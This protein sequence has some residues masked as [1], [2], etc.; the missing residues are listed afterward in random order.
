MPGSPLRSWPQDMV[1]LGCVPPSAEPRATDFI[2]QMIST[3]ERIIAHGHGYAADGDVFFDVTSLP[4]YGR[5]SGRAQEENRSEWGGP[6]HVPCSRSNPGALCCPRC[7]RGA[8]WC[9]RP[10]PHCAA[11]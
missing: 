2:P 11:P 3:I 5:L 9:R 8:A 7:A 10:T 1:A 6:P 4:G